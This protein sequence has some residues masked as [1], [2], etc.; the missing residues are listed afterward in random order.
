MAPNYHA[1]AIGTAVH[2][3]IR[4]A[5]LNLKE[6][7]QRAD[8]TP[9][10]LARRVNGHSSFTWDELVKVVEITGVT[11][12]ELAERAEKIRERAA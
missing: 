2:S 7:G 8:I 10:T 12:A 5:G 3:I 1:A 4:E 9:R 6:F 11:F